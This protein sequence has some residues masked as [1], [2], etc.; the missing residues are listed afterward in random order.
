M[1]IDS[2]TSFNLVHVC[3]LTNCLIFINQVNDKAEV[4]VIYSNPKNG[5]N[6]FQYEVHSFPCFYKCYFNVV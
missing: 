4:I 5:L 6:E 3:L 2:S 1:V